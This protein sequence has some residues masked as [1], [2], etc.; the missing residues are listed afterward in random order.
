MYRLIKETDHFNFFFD[1]GWCDH[2]FFLQLALVPSITLY[3][4]QICHSCTWKPKLSKTV[5]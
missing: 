1:A 4:K 3:D 5:Q 2:T